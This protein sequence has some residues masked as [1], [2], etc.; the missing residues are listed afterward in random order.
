MSNT[1]TL[2][3]LARTR[4]LPL[5]PRTIGSFTLSRSRRATFLA[6]TDKSRSSPRP[7]SSIATKLAAAAEA[8]KA[9]EANEETKLRPTEIAEAH[10]NKPS[11]GAV[12]DQQIEDEERAELERS[13]L[14]TTGLSYWR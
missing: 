9:E 5:I 13:V 7:A 1:L 8:E 10:G 3:K 12:I 4:M 2:M 14:F 11:R 6:S